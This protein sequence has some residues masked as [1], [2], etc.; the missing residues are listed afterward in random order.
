MYRLAGLGL[1]DDDELL[2]NCYNDK[3][4]PLKL[5]TTMVQHI[6]QSISNKLAK[7]EK[8]KQNFL[9]N[10]EINVLRRKYNAR[11][12]KDRNLIGPT[13]KNDVECAEMDVA[14]D[15][16]QKGPTDPKMN[17]DE[18]G[19]SDEIQ[20]RD[21]M[22]GYAMWRAIHVEMGKRKEKEKD[23]ETAIN[24]IT[25]SDCTTD[26]DN[27]HFVNMQTRKFVSKSKKNLKKKGESKV[28]RGGL[29]ELGKGLICVARDIS[30]F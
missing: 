11:V 26:D 19:W 30:T 3:D 17:K 29:T 28:V 25:S 23:E 21:Q 5:G 18:R 20:D 6:A 7:S 4:Y 13:Y 22:G 12:K 9:E 2:H 15:P 27:Y 14:M 16:H 8:K 1:S 10:I 24:M